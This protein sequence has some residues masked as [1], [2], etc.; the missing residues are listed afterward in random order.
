[1]NSCYLSSG[2]NNRTIIMKTFF[3]PNIEES[4][5]HIVTKDDAIE[6]RNV[7]THYCKLIEISVLEL[8]VTKLYC[9]V[10]YRKRQIH[11]VEALKRLKNHPNLLG[12]I[13]H[14]SDGIH[15]HIQTEL[16]DT[17]YVLHKFEDSK[18]Y[19]S[20]SDTQWCWYVCIL[21]S[22][23]KNVAQDAS[24]YPYQPPYGAYSC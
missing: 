8:W 12:Y 24:S 18:Q 9:F 7:L 11:E 23:Q 1:M 4:W 20:K 14:W 17:T 22:W 2:W 15:L 21:R 19:S 10:F 3:L 5:T 16:C 6:K 13:V